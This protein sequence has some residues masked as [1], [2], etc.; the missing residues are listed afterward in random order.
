MD[1]YHLEKISG[2]SH[3][4]CNIVTFNSIDGKKT[5]H[6]ITVRL[7]SKDKLHKAVKDG[8]LEGV[9]KVLKRGVDIDCLQV[10]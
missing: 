5:F 9:K 1:G 6:V 10:C 3:N 2:L 8:D 4:V 7:G